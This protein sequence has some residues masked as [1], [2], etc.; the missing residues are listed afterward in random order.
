MNHHRYI[1]R[2]VTTIILQLGVACLAIAETTRDFGAHV[3]HCKAMPSVA[4]DSDL[5]SQI[6]IVRDKNRGV[7]NIA[8]MEKTT[9]DP[10]GK[11][12]RGKV[13][14]HWSDHNGKMGTIP[15]REIQ[16]QNA[17][18][19]IGEFDLVGNAMMTFDILVSVDE[20]RPPYSFRLKKHF[21]AE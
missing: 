15:M 14:A 7:L 19:Y 9:D 12:V 2:L 4:L 18:Y 11:P 3:V 8:I 13:T 1:G 5:A 20:N 17:I 6:N 21:L 10:M 16:L